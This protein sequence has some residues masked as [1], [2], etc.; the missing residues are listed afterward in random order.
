MEIGTSGGGWRLW[1]SAFDGGDGQRWPFDCG[2]R[3]RLWQWQ[4]IE[5]AFHGSGCSCVQWRGKLLHVLRHGDGK[6]KV[7][8]TTRGREGGTRRGN[9][10]HS[11]TH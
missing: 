11:L 7:A 2:D 6:A 9:A 3:R 10:E 4:T 8:G 5:T 1:A